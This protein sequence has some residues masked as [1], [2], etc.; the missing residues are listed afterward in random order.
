MYPAG[1]ARNTTADL[2]GIL[3]HKWN[4]LAELAVPNG[5]AGAAKQL[6]SRYS[7]MANKSAAGIADING[8]DLH[9][10]GK[11]E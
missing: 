7:R 2:K 5:E 3:S 6:T 10:H 8:F 9:V 1:H 4:K 11:F